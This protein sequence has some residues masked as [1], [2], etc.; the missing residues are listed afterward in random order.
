MVLKA[1]LWLNSGSGSRS[2]AQAAFD[3]P[4]T[5]QFTYPHGQ[6]TPGQVRYYQPLN[7]ICDGTVA[8]NYTAQV[9]I[10]IREHREFI[11]SQLLLACLG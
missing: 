11:F 3:H 2:A 5:S 10:D 1:G 4:G 8:G 6:L 9:A 7:H